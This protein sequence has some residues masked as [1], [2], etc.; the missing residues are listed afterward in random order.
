MG[1]GVDK[2][3]KA[4]ASELALIEQ[5]CYQEGGCDLC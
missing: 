4:K 1:A 5:E 2:V 3:L